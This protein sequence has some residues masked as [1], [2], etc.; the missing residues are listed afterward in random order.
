[1]YM[2]LAKVAANGINQNPKQKR[3]GLVRAWMPCLLIEETC[4]G[5]RA[6]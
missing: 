4:I 2:D 5:I 6:S 3:S 1:M